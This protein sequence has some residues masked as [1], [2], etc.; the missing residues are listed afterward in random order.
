MTIAFLSVAHPCSPLISTRKSPSDSRSRYPKSA[1]GWFASDDR[2]RVSGGQLIPLGR[3]DEKVKV[4]GESVD[5]ARLN[6]IW[7]GILAERGVPLAGCLLALPD[8]RLG[9]V[10]SLV[11]EEA[12]EGQLLG[13]WHLSTRTSCPSNASAPSAGWNSCHARRWEKFSVQVLS[14]WSGR[15]WERK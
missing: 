11:Y 12:Q 5:L 8:V 9:H 7:E 14:R 4:S 13:A 2:G 3:A 10:V 1:D 15:R 6:R